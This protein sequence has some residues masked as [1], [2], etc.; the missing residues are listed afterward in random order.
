[1]ETIGGGT[2]HGPFAYITNVTLDEENQFSIE[3]FSKSDNIDEITTKNKELYQIL[4]SKFNDETKYLS[5]YR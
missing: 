4:K 1:M 2:A 3:A 5:L